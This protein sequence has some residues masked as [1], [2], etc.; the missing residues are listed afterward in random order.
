MID[1]RRETAIINRK[2]LGGISMKKAIATI[3]TVGLMLAFTACGGNGENGSSNA[4][5]NGGG[6]EAP[7]IAEAEATTENEPTPESKMQRL[8]VGEVAA[9]DIFEFRLNSA[10]FAIAV[11]NTLGERYLLPVEFNPNSRNPFVAPT[12]RT[13][14]SFDYTLHNTNRSGSVVKNISTL[15][16]SSSFM[17]NHGCGSFMRFEYSGVS[18]EPLNTHIRARSNQ[19]PATGGHRISAGSQYRFTGYSEIQVVVDDLS[20]AFYLRIGLP[21]SS[22]EIEEFLYVIDGRNARREYSYTGTVTGRIIEGSYPMAGFVCLEILESDFP[23]AD[24]L[25]RATRNDDGLFVFFEGF[26][27]HNELSI[28][29]TITVTGQLNIYR[30]LQDEITVSSFLDAV[31]INHIPSN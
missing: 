10:E 23:F 16:N 25:A 4:L 8:A 6:N 28:S 7:I 22:G 26:R 1:E 15:L 18:Y 11:S 3:L 20:D 13:L 17:L 31:I 2:N 12:G 9:T 30:N 21:N 24:D 14:V 5:I 19:S 29:D 27:E